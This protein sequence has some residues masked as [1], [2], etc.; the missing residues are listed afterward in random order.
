MSD[1]DFDRAKKGLDVLNIEEE[2]FSSL[3]GSVTA[4]KGRE[5]HSLVYVQVK[6]VNKGMGNLEDIIHGE[7]ISSKLSH[8][9]IVKHI[10]WYQTPRHVWVVSELCAGGT[11]RDVLIHHS[12]EFD[13]IRDLTLDLSAALYYIHVEKGIGHGDLRPENIYLTE[14]GVAKL[15]G[16]AIAQPISS[17][18][19]DGMMSIRLRDHVK[20]H[21]EYA[22]PEL[23]R[24]CASPSS[25]DDGLLL[26]TQSDAWSL[27]ILL[28]ECTTGSPPF[29]G[30]SFA[31]LMERICDDEPN[32]HR[33]G[34]TREFSLAP[35]IKLLLDKKAE[36]RIWGEALQ[37]KAE[38]LRS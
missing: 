23:L 37:V 29:S 3:D 5:K 17:P 20:Q 38:S 7:K 12:L 28:Y 11:L 35:F 1:Q 30:T 13:A 31:H 6:R 34:Q 9:R 8:E 2:L 16:F 27:G 21:A 15:G 19:T 26:T 10:A 33:E 14:N 22:A 32:Y 18:M 24:T 36:R 4:F 25:T